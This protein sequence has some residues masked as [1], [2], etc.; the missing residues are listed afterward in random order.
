MDTRFSNYPFDEQELI[1]KVRQHFL[2]KTP[3]NADD[4]ICEFEAV[5]RKE[6]IKILSEEVVPD[7][8]CSLWSQ[9]AEARMDEM[10]AKL[11]AGVPLEI[12][13]PI[14]EPASLSLRIQLKAG[15]IA[16]KLFNEELGKR[17][18]RRLFGT[19]LRPP[20]KINKSK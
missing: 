20:N 15:D 18:H 8:E 4:F 17:V 6:G 3:K 9:R 19:Q 14:S 13:K 5:L 1:E 16:A 7:K 11:K 12:P 2:L 10:L